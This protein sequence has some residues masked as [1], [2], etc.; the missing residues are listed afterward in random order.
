VLD[1]FKSESKN[2]TGCASVLTHACVLQ[3]SV[4]YFEKKLFTFIFFSSALNYLSSFFSYD[5]RSTWLL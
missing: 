4:I 1:Y 3:A 2:K 5:C